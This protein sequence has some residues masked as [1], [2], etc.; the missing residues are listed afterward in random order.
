ME[1]PERAWIVDTG[2][3][4]RFQCLR[5]AVTRVDA[6]LYTHSHTDHIVG[7]DDLRPFCFPNR[8]IDIHASP[9]TMADLRRV[10]AF[11]FNDPPLPG[12]LHPCPKEITGPFEIGATLVTPLAAEHGRAHIYGYLFER[13]GVPLAAYLSDCKR[14][15]LGVVERIAGVHTLIID[16]LRHTPHPTHMNLEEALALSAQVCPESTWLTHLCHDLGHEETEAMLPSGV[17]IAYDGLKLHL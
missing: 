15:A 16:A 11:A 10:F 9:E 12:Y 7:F 2:P 13:E 5:E 8:Y 3:D 14:V 1:T 17:R 4:F 6:V